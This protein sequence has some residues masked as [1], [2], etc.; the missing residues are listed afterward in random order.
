MKKVDSVSDTK[1]WYYIQLVV[2]LGVYILVNSYGYKWTETRFNVSSE[3]LDKSG[4]ESMI[5]FCKASGLA[6][7]SHGISFPRKNGLPN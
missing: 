3:R 5:L 6:T 1:I 4:M 2:W 7:Y